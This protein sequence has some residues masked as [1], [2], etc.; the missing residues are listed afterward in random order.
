MNPF[1]TPSASAP[2]SGNT[3]TG[4]SSGMVVAPSNQ[5]RDSQ[6]RTVHDDQGPVIDLLWR[7]QVE[8]LV[9]PGIGRFRHAVVSQGKLALASDGGYV[10]RLD[11][12]AQDPSVSEILVS[13]RLGGSIHGLFQ[14][15]L[16]HHIIISFMSGDNFYLNADVERPVPLGKMKGVVVSSGADR[17]LPHLH[18]HQ[19]LD[20]CLLL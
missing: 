17:A 7:K 16:G 19:L 18:N 10:V 3:S 4:S 11:L 1:D 13:K 6:F 2:P 14:E 20:P 15:P 12:G 5:Y 8:K 9:N